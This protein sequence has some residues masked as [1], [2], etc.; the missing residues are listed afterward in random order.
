MGRYY[1]V[2]EWRTCRKLYDIFWSLEFSIKPEYS[3]QNEL[4]GLVNNFRKAITE[5][6]VDYEAIMIS[7]NLWT[8]FGY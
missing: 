5:G 1:H 2:C 4:R 6:E 8:L 7:K 3:M